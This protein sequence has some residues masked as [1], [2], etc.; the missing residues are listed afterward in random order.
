MRYLLFQVL[1]GV[2][3]LAGAAVIASH[4][5]TIGFDSM[6]FDGPDALGVWLVFF[7]FGIKAAFPFLNGWLQDAYPEATATG[8]VA[9]L[10]LP[11]SWPSMRWREA[12]LEPTC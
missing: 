3:L 7:A 2:L 6:A 10:H 8:T 4:S 11:P 5:G 1:S 9:L 12:L